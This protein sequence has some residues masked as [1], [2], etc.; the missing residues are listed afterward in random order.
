MCT[1]YFDDGGKMSLWK[2]HRSIENK[3][4]P[5]KSEADRDYLTPLL[6]SDHSCFFN[7]L[8][9]TVL[10]AE[11]GTTTLPLTINNAEYGNSFVCSPYDLYVSCAREQVMMKGGMAMKLSLGGVFPLLAPL[12]RLTK[13]NRVIMVNN[14]LFSTNLYPTISNERLVDLL[15][16]LKEQFPTHAIMFRSLDSLRHGERMAALKKAGCKLVPCRKVYYSDTTSPS[17]F[18]SRMFL[19]DQALAKN[20][21]YVLESVVDHPEFLWERAQDLYYKL[22]IEKHSKYNLDL[23]AAFFKHISKSKKV[24]FYVLKKGERVDGLLG[25][26]EEDGVITAPYFGYDPTVPSEEGLYRLISYYLLQHAKEKKLLLNH[27]AGAGNFKT[28]RRAQGHIEYSAVYIDHLPIPGRT[29]WKALSA[30]MNSV[31]TKTMHQW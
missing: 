28:L 4:I 25:Y 16:T 2:I 18:R 22:Y 24:E 31:G 9:T 12:L 29:T 21:D 17:V 6:R 7:N 15:K 14:W 11:D 13:F 20:S 27:S 26:Y 10:L 19:S 8:K 3:E 1:N 5:W 30:V 23:T